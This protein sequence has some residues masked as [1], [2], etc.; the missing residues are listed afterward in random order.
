MSLAKNTAGEKL[1]IKFGDGET[2]ET[3]T[4]Y[5]SVNAER[6]LNL[7]SDVFEGMVP[8]C[9][10]PSAA[11]KPVMRVKG[12]SWSAEGQGIADGPS[13]LALVQA[14]ANAETINAKVIQDVSG[15]LG[16]FTLTGPIVI[17]SITLGGTR[18]EDQTF[19]I[20]IG[21]AGDFDIEANA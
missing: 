19:S 16:G 5:C 17:R 8:D 12:L 10:D 21:A 2:S 18:G 11:A 14:W 15:A 7:T 20:S 4:H 3:F 1:L 9:D 6:T 13:A